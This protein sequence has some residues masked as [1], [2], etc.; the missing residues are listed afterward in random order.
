MLGKWGYRGYR[1]AL[2][3][4]KEYQKKN[5]EKVPKSYYGHSRLEPFKNLTFFKTLTLSQLL[6]RLLRSLIWK[7]RLKQKFY[8]LEH[9]EHLSFPTCCDGSKK[10]RFGVFLTCNFKSHTLCWEVG[11]QSKIGLPP[12]LCADLN[13]FSFLEG[14]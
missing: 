4:S 9:L 11:I 2:H 6:P 5:E 7:L 8:F 3:K 13:P 14:S 1:G 12:P 10:G